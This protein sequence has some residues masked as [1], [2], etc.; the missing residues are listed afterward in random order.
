MQLRLEDQSVAGYQT[1]LGTG[2]VFQLVGALPRCTKSW[3]HSG[4]GWW[5]QKDE[6]ASNIIPS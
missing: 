5:K 4:L 6:Q 1:H 2:V 3:V